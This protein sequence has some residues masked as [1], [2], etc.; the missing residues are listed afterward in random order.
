MISS[1]F[2]TCDADGPREGGPYWAV[3]NTYRIIGGAVQQLDPGVLT[4]D[5]ALAFRNF[6]ELSAL[7]TNT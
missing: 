7:E 4:V 3:G 1:D 2:I 5:P 6:Q